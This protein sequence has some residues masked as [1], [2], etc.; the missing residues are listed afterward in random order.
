MALQTGLEVEHQNLLNLEDAMFVSA[1]YAKKSGI[2][3]PKHSEGMTNN[4]EHIRGMSN[5]HL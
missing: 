1:M 2:E 5:P 4:Y 3:K